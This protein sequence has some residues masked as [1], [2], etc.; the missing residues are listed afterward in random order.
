[1]TVPSSSRRRTTT[2]VLIPAASLTCQYWR[3]V[4]LAP[5]V[6][7]TS[8]WSAAMLRTVPACIA[9][10]GACSFGASTSTPMCTG[11]RGSSKLPRIGWT[12]VVGANGQPPGAVGAAK[13][14]AST[15]RSVKRGS[16]GGRCDVVGLVVVVVGSVVVGSVGAGSVVA[17]GVATAVGAGVPGHVW[18]V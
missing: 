6:A 13:Q 11:S 2:P 15:L 8:K 3:Y 12:A 16:S 4:P 17:A 9:Y 18:P 14:R 7:W 1:L 5:W 10:T